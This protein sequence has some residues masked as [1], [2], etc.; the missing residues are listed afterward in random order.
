VAN[1]TI[2]LQGD[3]AILPLRGVVEFKL[4]NVGWSA[5]RANGAVDELGKLRLSD[6]SSLRYFVVLMRY[7]A[8]TLARWQKYWSAVSQELEASPEICSVVAVSWL[9]AAKSGVEVFRYGKWIVAQ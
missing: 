7:T 5:N 3:T 9:S 1:R 8:P 6:E 4:D 2:K